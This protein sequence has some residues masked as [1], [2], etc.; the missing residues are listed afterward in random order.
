[1]ALSDANKAKVRRY[2][3]YPD[4]NRELY[5]ALEGALVALSAEAV[6]EVE[7]IL[8]QLATLETTLTGGWSYQHVKRAEEVTLAGMD[9]LAAL[10]SE[11]TRLVRQLA[12]MLGVDI[13]SNP[14]GSGRS[15][16][17]AARG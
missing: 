7:A 17:L 12:A 4:V 8:T 13:R 16:G 5:H 9:G 3:G 1:M 6:T 15:A 10:R 11:G 2:L 14:F